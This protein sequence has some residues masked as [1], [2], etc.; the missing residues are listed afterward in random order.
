VETRN[1]KSNE[2]SHAIIGR[3]SRDLKARGED[4]LWE[5]LAGLELFRRNSDTCTVEIVEIDGIVR[6]AKNEYIRN[7]PVR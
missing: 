2:V 3:Q 7:E 6:K 4:A 5:W 1:F